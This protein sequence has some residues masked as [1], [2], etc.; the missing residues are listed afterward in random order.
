MKEQRTK[1]LER[2]VIKKNLPQRHEKCGFET[3]CDNNTI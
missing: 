1:R 2:M 3:K